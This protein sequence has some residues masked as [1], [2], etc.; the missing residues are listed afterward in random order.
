MK[1]DVKCL[2]CGETDKVN[3]QTGIDTFKWKHNHGNIDAVRRGT[4]ISILDSSPIPVKNQSRENI[5]DMEDN[6]KIRDME[7]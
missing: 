1:R 4:Y 5:I 2:L 7:A 6:N 3:G